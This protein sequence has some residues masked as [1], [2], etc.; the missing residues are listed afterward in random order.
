[1]KLTVK[2]QAKHIQK[3]L[4]RSSFSNMVAGLYWYKEANQ[5]A[6]NVARE[7][8]LTTRQ[9]AHITAILSTQC[10]WNT[11]KLNTEKVISLNTSGIF[12]SKKQI[13]ECWDVMFS[14]FFIPERRRK[15]HNFAETITNPDHNIAVI[16]RH[17]IRVA[18]DIESAK[19]ICITDKRYR[20][21]A[22]AYAIVADKNN[23]TVSQVQ[24]I[25]W[26]TYKDYVGR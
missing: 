2:Q 11:N 25:V 4:D 5:W 24:A 7:W 13:G 12:A 23:L 8:G 18:F 20:E 26:V 14:E 19:E 16:D 10:D 1:M 3:W 21:A 9:V 15:T 6:V 22:E 17:A